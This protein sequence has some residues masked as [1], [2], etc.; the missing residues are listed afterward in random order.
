MIMKG[1]NIG[2][3]AKQTRVFSAEDVAAYRRL[4]GDTGLAFGAKAETAVPGPLLAG[5]FS[6]LLGTKLP[7]R[8]TNWLKQQLEFPTGA[9]IGDRI[10]AVVEITRLRPE[11][12]L[13]NLRTT[14]TNTEGVIV[15]RG[16][17]LVLVKDLAGG[18]NKMQTTINAN[19][20]KIAYDICG[21]GDPLILIAGLGDDRWLWHR[22]IPYLAQDFQVI[23]FDNRGVGGTD[24]PAGP[25]SANMLAEDTAVLLQTLGIGQTAVLGHGMGGYVAQALVLAYPEIVSKLILSAT[26]FGGPHHIPITQEAL[27][28]L[29]DTNGSRT[30]QLKN[31]LRVSCA[32]GFSQREPEFVREWLHY[33]AAHPIDSAAY[34]AQLSIGLGLMSE[35]ACFEHKLKDVEVPT[36]VISGGQDKVVPPE[37]VALLAEKIPHNQ[38]V[39]IKNAGHYFPFEQ[40]ETAAKIVAKFLME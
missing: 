21:H 13:V 14:C 38:T 7:G 34:Q 12:E 20:I 6:D 22:M 30:T 33:F 15:C 23:A 32:A 4:T 3:S 24:A 28:I 8:G 40:P 1:L 35:D 5:M 36:L 31:R 25:Y 39:I 2:Q 18:E 29:M 27:T 10:T 11:K 19:G 26:N 17:S 16:E 37:N 9:H